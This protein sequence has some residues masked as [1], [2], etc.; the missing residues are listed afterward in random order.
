MSF[1]D[2]GDLSRRSRGSRCDYGDL[3]GILLDGKGEKIYSPFSD[4]RET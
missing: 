4:R 2:H 1:S 3:G